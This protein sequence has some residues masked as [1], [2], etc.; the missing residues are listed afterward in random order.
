[1][2]EYTLLTIYTEPRPASPSNNTGAVAGGVVVAIL[3]VII[4]LV[5]AAFVII[6]IMWV[7]VWNDCV[8]YN[9]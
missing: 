5:G 8:K 4:L 6:Y 1:M 2:F 9:P 7:I 3:I